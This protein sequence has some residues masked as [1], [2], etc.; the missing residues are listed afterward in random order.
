MEYVSLTSADAVHV[1]ARKTGGEQEKQSPS[2]KITTT[3][4]FS[5]CNRLQLTN[6]GPNHVVSLCG[7]GTGGG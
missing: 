1:H 7:T 3:F 2:M 6:R 5:P 4:S